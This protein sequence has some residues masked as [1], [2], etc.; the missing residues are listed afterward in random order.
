MH[1]N[2]FTNEV[3]RVSNRSGFPRHFAVCRSIR[4]PQF[5]L[6]TINEIPANVFTPS[7]SIIIENTILENLD[8]LYIEH[9][10]SEDSS[11]GDFY[12]WNPRR[13]ES[14]RVRYNIYNIYLTNDNVHIPIVLIDN[15]S[16]LPRPECLHI[17][18]NARLFDNFV[19]EMEYN[20]P[21]YLINY[22]RERDNFLIIPEEYE[23]RLRYRNER[24]RNTVYIPDVGYV[25]QDTTYT[26]E[27]PRHLDYDNYFNPPSRR[28]RDEEVNTTSSVGAG[29]GGSRRS[30][31]PSLTTTPTT[32]PTTTNSSSRPQLQPFTIEALITRA[33]NENMNCPISMNPIKADTACVTTCQHIFERESFVRWYTSNPSCPVCRE[34]CSVCN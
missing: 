12:A 6:L 13:A 3:I 19:S 8:H 31:R 34:S 18:I 33:V 24:R 11:A 7:R 30:R 23:H 17:P 1:R 14:Q 10:N 32:T 22:I 28:N 15:V 20:D 25:E 29:S 5:Q 26:R 27:R 21:Y 4:P 9:C 16:V 2:R